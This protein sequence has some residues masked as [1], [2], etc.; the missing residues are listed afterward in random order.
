MK[1]RQIE[2]ILVVSVWRWGFQSICYM[3]IKIEKSENT[4]SACRGGYEGQHFLLSIWYNA[5]AYNVAQAS[6]C[7]L[8]R[9]NYPMVEISKIFIL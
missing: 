2:V 4:K 3:T 7:Q 5:H 1:K 8:L 6:L 9:E